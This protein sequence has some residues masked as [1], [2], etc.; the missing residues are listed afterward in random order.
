MRM[1]LN[2]PLRQYKFN[3]G[4]RFPWLPEL[5]PGSQAADSQVIGDAPKIDKEM[6]FSKV[7]THH[8]QT[9]VNIVHLFY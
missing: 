3:T 6:G 8:S 2:D 7:C 1:Q 9:R 4:S 5:M